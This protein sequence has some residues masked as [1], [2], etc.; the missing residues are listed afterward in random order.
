MPT[1]CCVPDCTKKGYREDD[2]SK[3]SYFV[4]PKE[5]ALRKK[6]IH[7]IRREEG[8]YFKI[9]SLTKVCSRHFRANDLKKTLAGKMTLQP[10]PGAVP[11]L[12]S[13][14]RTSPRKRKA[15]T[16]RESGEG[17]SSMIVDK[18]ADEEIASDDADCDSFSIGT[19]EA[20]VANLNAS[21]TREHVLKTPPKKTPQ[22]QKGIDN[23]Q[24]KRI[25]QLEQ[26]IAELQAQV[27]DLRRRNEQLLSQLFTVER[28]KESDS[29]LNFYTGFPNWD[30]FMAVFKYL[31]P[32][33]LAFV[34]TKGI[35]RK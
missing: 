16:P 24:E 33:L 5:K 34:N 20:D 9:T 35:I 30:T 23:S 31:N 7:A 15:P 1:H 11:S 2:G 6:W 32:G 29:A 18:E 26:Q 8:K 22:K 10:W 25:N 3:I 12:F 21:L 17:S 19:S 28:F 4:F 13:W 27:E 14:T